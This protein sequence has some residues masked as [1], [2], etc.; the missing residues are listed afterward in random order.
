MHQQYLFVFIVNRCIDPSHPIYIFAYVHIYVYVVTPIG[1][2]NPFP[3]THLRTH[4]YAESEFPLHFVPGTTFHP[5]KN[6]EMYLFFY[7]V[8]PYSSLVVTII[9]IATAR[10]LADITLFQKKEKR[11]KILF[12]C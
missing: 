3:P 9:S 4:H 2:P 12:K 11:E 8:F 7:R 10:V 1:Q 5:L 6:R